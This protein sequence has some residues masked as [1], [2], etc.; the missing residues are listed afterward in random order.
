MPW[1]K[2]PRM[3]SNRRHFHRN[4]SE[5]DLAEQHDGKQLIQIGFTNGYLGI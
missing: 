1:Y 3:R 2:I 5:L 4:N